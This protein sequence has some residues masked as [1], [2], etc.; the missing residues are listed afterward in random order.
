MTV[1]DITDKSPNPET[2]RMLE[3]LLERAKEGQ[4]RTIFLVNGWN[5]DCWTTNWVIDARN[6]RRRLIGQVAIA[7][8]D[9]LTKQSLDDGDSIL[10]ETLYG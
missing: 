5:D 9:L 10:A 4:L 8:F 2:V 6:S 3:R 1:R 7:Q